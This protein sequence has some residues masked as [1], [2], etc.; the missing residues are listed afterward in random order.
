[1]QSLFLQSSDMD[2][3]GG[4]E[5][6]S[7]MTWSSTEVEVGLHSKQT[8]NDRPFPG[9]A[10]QRHSLNSRSDACFVKAII[11][12][13]SSRVYKVSHTLCLFPVLFDSKNLQ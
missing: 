11:Q 4:G 2:W 7:R 1:M 3:S 12:I 5:Q 10:S 8:A 9:T 13:A 6:Y